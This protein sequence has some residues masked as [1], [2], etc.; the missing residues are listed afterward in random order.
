M[1]LS[2]MILSRSLG[3]LENICLYRRR[4]RRRSHCCCLI[5]FTFSKSLV[6]SE[7]LIW[8]VPERW[9]FY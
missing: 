6:G 3:V 9:V 2:I 7:I 4:R 8:L 1:C 5:I